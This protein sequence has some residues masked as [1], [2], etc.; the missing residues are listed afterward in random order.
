M[1]F[2]WRMFSRRV[3][4]RQR[5]NHPPPG[6]ASFRA[7][8]QTHKNDI[9][10]LPAWGQENHL[11][12][13]GLQVCDFLPFSF[14]CEI[15]MTVPC[16]NQAVK[17]SYQGREAGAYARRHIMSL[18]QLDTFLPRRNFRVYADR[19]RRGSHYFFSLLVSF[20]PPIQFILH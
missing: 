14:F 19:C 3:S 4:R 18:T 10:F 15:R 20:F 13:T 1:L 8:I 7:Q 17:R 5:E 12:L 9:M 6:A 2:P 11:F 16:R